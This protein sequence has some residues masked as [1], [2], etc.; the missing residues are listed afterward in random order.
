MT[1]NSGEKS[2]AG[3]RVLIVEDEGLVAYGIVQ[4]LEEVGARSV[5]PFATMI[6]AL[7]GITK[8]DAVDGAILDI[9]LGDQTSYPLADALQTTGIP[10]LFLTGTDRFSLPPRFERTAHL[11][12]PHSDAE[13]MAELIKLDMC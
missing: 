5:G 11:R 1:V 13:L 6:E 3:C 9:G 12:K 8:F 4:F 10:F 2:L 7:D